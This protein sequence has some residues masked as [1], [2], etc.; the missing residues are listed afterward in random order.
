MAGVQ[1]YLAAVTPVNALSVCD[2]TYAIILLDSVCVCVWT[3]SAVA[4]ELIESIDR[5]RACTLPCSLS[6]WVSF[7]LL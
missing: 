5:G 2:A 4:T 6:P 1:D 7:L 3:V